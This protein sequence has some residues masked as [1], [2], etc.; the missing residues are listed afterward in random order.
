MNRSSF[1]IV[2]LLLY[3][4]ILFSQVAIDTNATSP[5][6]SAMLDVK[7]TIKGILIPRMT[8]SERNAIVNPI[9][10][11]MIFCTNCSTDGSLSFYSNGE[12][13]T[14]SYCVTPS[15]S[16]GD[17]ILSPGQIIW[18]WTVVAGATGYK[19]NTTSGYGNAIDMGSATSKTE[20]GIVCD[21]FYTRYVWAYNNCGVSEPAM[22]SQTIPASSPDAPTAVSNTST[23]SS[24]VWNWNPVSGASGYKWNITNNYATAIDIGTDTTKT[25]TGLTC[26][27]AYTRYVWAYSACGT[28]TALT[29]NQ[30]SSDCS[31]TCGSSITITHLAGAVA[32]VDKTVTYG[33]VTNIPGETSKC[34]ITSNLGADHQATTVDDA[35]EASAGWYWQFDHMQGYQYTTTRTPNTAWQ[36]PIYG[37][38]DWQV[39]N[40][41]CAIEIGSAWRIPTNIEWYNVGAANSWNTWNSP[42]KIH[43]AGY[44]DNNDGSLYN[45][46]IYGYYWSSAQNTEVSGSGWGLYTTNGASGVSVYYRAFGFSIRCIRD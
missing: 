38:V 29:L 5:D 18:N 28:S 26:N 42:L 17:N 2:F 4:G 21:T 16:P 46:G 13:K 35:A 41:P 19:W 14:Y 3:S 10:G 7:S 39:A 15:S 33:T 22:L 37:Y 12:W 31:F 27:T 30:T 36:W 20:T 24:I 11:L 44:L 43:S 6:P 45:R 32:P 25:E 40:D 34:W 9:N 8:L 23:Q 1:F